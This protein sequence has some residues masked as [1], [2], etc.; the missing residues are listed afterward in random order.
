VKSVFK[1]IAKED[2]NEA[3]WNG[4]NEAGTQVAS[5]V[6]FYRLR[7]ADDDLSKKMGKRGRP[8]LHSQ[9]LDPPG[10]L[11]PWHFTP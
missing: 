5:G 7:S 3:F 10:P 6:Y 1:G 11:S 8:L 2:I 9:K 4:T